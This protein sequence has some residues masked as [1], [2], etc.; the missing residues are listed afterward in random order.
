M[1]QVTRKGLITMAAAS[2]VIAMGSGAA[3]ADSAAQGSAANSPGVLSGNAVQLPVHAPVNVCGNTVNVVGLLSPAFANGCANKGHQGGGAVAHGKAV[4][5]PGVGSGNHVQAPIDAP[6]NL[7]GN[8]VSVIG[9][10][11]P[12]FGNDC[13]NDAGHPGTPQHPGKPQHPGHPGL[14][15]HPGK[16]QHPGHPGHPGGHQQPCPPQHPGQPGH[17]GHPGQPQHPGQPGQPGH[18]GVPQHPVGPIAHQPAKPAGPVAPVRAGVPV[19]HA[20]TASQAQAQALAAAPQLAHTGSEGLGFAVPAA[21]GLL[22]GGA[23]LYRRGRA[24][25]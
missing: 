1:R 23:V 13:A 17:P 12:A 25:Q 9:V 4:D 5:S 16:P 11:N 14:P 18:P 3:H 7:C 8:S 22:L 6:V 10:G 19:T 20:V 21:A 15:H 24:A 2:G